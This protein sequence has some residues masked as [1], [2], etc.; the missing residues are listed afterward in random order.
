MMRAAAVG[1]GGT[2]L[3]SCRAIAQE[4]LS[5]FGA[6]LPKETSFEL[7]LV[8]GLSTITL[9]GKNTTVVAF[10][11]EFI[12][13]LD[14]G[15][16]QLIGISIFWTKPQ[17]GYG[18]PNFPDFS[19]HALRSILSRNSSNLIFPIV[20]G[21]ILIGVRDGTDKSEIMEKLTHFGL[22]NI[23]ILSATL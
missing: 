20:A 2:S 8:E 15:C 11:P 9:N 16:E 1:V 19:S 12:F 21:E 5:K 6:K 17:F 3:D 7:Y 13:L 18:D 14:V 10:P 22:Q 4:A 23:D